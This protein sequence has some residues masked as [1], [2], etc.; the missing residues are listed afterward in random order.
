MA[1]VCVRQLRSIQ[2]VAL[3]APTWL[4]ITGIDY[5]G[6]LGPLAT[7]AA[8]ALFRPTTLLLYMTFP[9]RQPD[10]RFYYLDDIYT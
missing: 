4:W 6:N 8:V 3:S 9:P 7:P 10:G 1:C 5:H 2:A